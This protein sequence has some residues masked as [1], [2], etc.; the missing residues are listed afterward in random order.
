MGPPDSEAGLGSLGE[1][2]PHG[3]V[4]WFP[5]KKE[6]PAFTPARLGGAAETEMFADQ[7]E[8]GSGDGQT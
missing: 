3:R 2:P 7:D 5:E 4:T 8:G 6:N 1:R